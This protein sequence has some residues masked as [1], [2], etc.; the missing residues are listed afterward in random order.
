MSLWSVRSWPKGEV[1]AKWHVSQTIRYWTLMTL[2]HSCAV[3]IAAVAG[4]IAAAAYLDAKYLVR[5]DLT[6]GS[7]AGN[8]AAAAA[9]ITGRTKQDRL[10][11][12]R[13]CTTPAIISL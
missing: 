12:Y 8:V 3:P 1:L 6:A 2:A 5:H 4:A 11:A 13:E 7:V 9:F 10:L